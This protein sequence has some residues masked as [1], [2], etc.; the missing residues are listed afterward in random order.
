VYRKFGKRLFDIVA[1]LIGLILLA[2]VFLIIALLV[3][4]LSK[5]SY[6]LCS[7]GRVWE[8]F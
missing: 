7:K 3:K 4:L 8:E 5:G 2:P 6:P 1:S